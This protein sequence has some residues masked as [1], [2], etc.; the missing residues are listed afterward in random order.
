MRTIL[1]FIRQNYLSCKRRSRMRMIGPL[2][3]LIAAALIFTSSGKARIAQTPA[4]AMPGLRG[5]AAPEYL[6]QHSLYSSLVEAVKAA[7]PEAAGGEAR[8]RLDDRDAGYQ[9][10]IDRTFT[11]IKK[12]TPSDGS[13]W[14]GVVAV[15][16][17]TAIVGAN[18]AIGSNEGQGSA[19]IFERDKGGA[20]NWGFVKKLTASNGSNFDAFGRSLAIYGDTAIVGA[21]GEDIGSNNAQGSVYIFERNQGGANNWGF[22]KKLTAS[23]GSK[24]DYFGDSVAIYGDTAIVGT[25]NDAI[26][27]NEGQG[28]AYIFERNK[29]GANNWGEVKKLIASDGATEDEFGNSV[30]I[31]GDMAIVGAYKDAVGSNYWQGSAYIFE[32]NQGGGAN[33]GVVKKLTASDGAAVDWFGWSVAIYGDTAIVGAVDDAYGNTAIV[34]AS[35]DA[36]IRNDGQGS[37]YVFERNKGG[38]KNW[39][40]VKKLTASD[41][42]KKDA[43]GS[44]LAIYGDTAI[45]GANGDAIG[46]NEGQG[47]AYIFERN[48]GGGANWGAVKKLTASGGAKFDSFGGSVAIYGDTAIVGASHAETGSKKKQG[49]AYVFSPRTLGR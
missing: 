45:V 35:R 23:D 38:A 28:S 29:G 40:E 24:E 25:S 48:Q 4:A 41:G 47:S 8:V 21:T 49:S 10:P 19:Y 27:S 14:F 26:G 32:R 1:S 9:A 16:G 34:G 18:E 39:G 15:Y 46:S 7:R 12:L 30:A 33:W 13:N 11:Q 31:Y 5:E 36:N 20:N 42:A 37:A 17:N 43:F 2:G 44:S 3:L 6:K 22:V